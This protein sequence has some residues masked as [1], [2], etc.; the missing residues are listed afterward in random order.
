[1]AG[2]RKREFDKQDALNSA[3]KVFWKKGFLGAS[4]S[5]LTQGMGINKPSMYATFGNKEDLF[6]E[7][8]KY[9]LE[10]HAKSHTNYLYESGIELSDR[11]RNY[12][13]SV[14]AAQC[15]AMNPK[16][17][18]ISLCVAEAAGDCM[19]DNARAII[20]EAGTY[21]VT[22]LTELLQQDDEAQALQ[23]TK[24]AAEKALFLVTILHGTA[25]MARAGKTLTELEPIIDYAMLGLNFPVITYAE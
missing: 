18:Y 2:G 19:P 7:A 23:L 25:S 20:D 1:M 13:T 8:T 15:D 11:I 5:D 10:H 14:V 9:Y 12:L 3:M 21:A 6:L 22:L 24:S 17:C 16:G 4:L